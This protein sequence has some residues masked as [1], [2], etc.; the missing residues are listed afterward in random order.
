MTTASHDTVCRR[1]NSLA[2]ARSTFDPVY[3]D[4]VRYLNPRGGRFSVTDNDGRRRDEK[5]NNEAP[6]FAVRTLASGMMAGITSPARPWFRLTT[7]DPEL[8]KYGPVRV[9]LDD[10]SD[11]LN[12][13][14]ARSNL[15]TALP[16]M[17][18]QI[19]CFGTSAMSVLEHPSRTV[20]FNVFP[21]GQYYIASSKGDGI[22][23]FYRE[24]R[25]TVAEVVELFGIDNVSESVKSAYNSGSYD[26][27]VDLIHEVRPRMQYDRRSLSINNAPW[28]SAYYETGRGGSNREY[29]SAHKLRESGYREFPIMAPRWDAFDDECY[30]SDAPGWEAIGSSKALQLKEIRKQ[31]L[32]DKGT[33]PPMVGSM[34]LTNSPVSVLPGGLTYEDPATQGAGLRPAYEPNYGWLQALDTDIQVVEKRINDAF[35]VNLFLM[36]SEGLGDR[37]QVTATEIAQRHE[38]KLLMLGPVL[39]RLNDELLDPMIDRVFA[40]ML[41]NG[42]LP[43]RPEALRGIDLRVEYVS[44]MAQAQKMV[45]LASVER[46][47]GFAGNLAAAFPTVLDKVNA[48]EMLEEYGKISGAPARVIRDQDEVD[49]LRSQRQQEQAMQNAAA[50]AQQGAGAAKTLSE[51]DITDP[52]LLKQMT[53]L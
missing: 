28:V 44:I 52:S 26:Q 41:R 38:E 17:Y 47:A 24:F 16:K 37:R 31:Q 30:G 42:M 19:G 46:F 8:A 20:A 34:S 9:W 29:N 3:R 48:D 4:I 6:L 10:V 12:Q 21:V 5:I 27:W 32:I 40:I 43:E 13:V 33:N 25:K 36:I 2:L 45:G 15:Y 11:R 22:D 35:Y 53:G 1:L 49:Q 18:K 7:P 14:F 39:E 50:M 51:V 23:T